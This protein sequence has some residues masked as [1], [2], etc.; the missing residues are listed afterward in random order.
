MSMWLIWGGVFPAVS[1]WHGCEGKEGCCIRNKV[2]FTR[3]A[4]AYLEGLTGRLVWECAARHDRGRVTV[5]SIL[6]PSLQQPSKGKVVFLSPR[7]RGGERG[8][9]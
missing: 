3:V 6:E 8:N 9:R 7:K 2:A 4:I 5:A 1:C